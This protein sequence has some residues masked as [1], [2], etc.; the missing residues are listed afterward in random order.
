MVGVEAYVVAGCVRGVV[1]QIVIVRYAIPA[2]AEMR[3]MW[4]LEREST[5]YF[6]LIHGNT[7]HQK[8]CIVQHIDYIYPAQN[9]IIE[10]EDK[11][12][13]RFYMIITVGEIDLSTKSKEVLTNTGV[14]H[15]VDERSLSDGGASYVMSIPTFIANFNSENG[16]QYR[17]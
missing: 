16:I 6:R 8:S 15:Q 1:K 5:Y 12:A 9:T 13:N 11:R 10:T 4:I 17:F 3:M 7:I 2:E 14:S